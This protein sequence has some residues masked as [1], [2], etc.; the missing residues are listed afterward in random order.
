MNEGMSKKNIKRLQ[1]LERRY[2]TDALTG[3][4]LVLIT[5]VSK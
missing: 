5:T 4:T 1:D 3:T 2:R